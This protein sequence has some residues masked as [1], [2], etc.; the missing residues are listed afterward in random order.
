MTRAMFRSTEAKPHH[1]RGATRF[2]T[3]GFRCK[4]GDL[5]DLSGT[6]MR[7]RF[8]GKPEFKVGDYRDFVIAASGQAIRVPGAVVWVKR[9]SLFSKEYEAGVHFANLRPGLQQAIESFAKHGVIDPNAA[10]GSKTGSARGSKVRVEAADYYRVLGVARNA[11]EQQVHEA[12]RALAKKLHPDVNPSAEAAEE[13]R[14]VTDAYQVLKD[15]SLRN[16]Y[17]MNANAA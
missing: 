9:K 15:P 14:K 12:Y 4:E 13:F 8:E 3:E 16:Q 10:K 1:L 5:A 2:N 11:S 17:D 6:G 7:L